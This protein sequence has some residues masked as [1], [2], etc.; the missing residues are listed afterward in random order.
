MH[1]SHD[2]G[3]HSKS[4]RS[5]GTKPLNRQVFS[6]SSAEGDLFDDSSHGSVVGE[7]ANDSKDWIRQH[8]DFT[9]AVVS[10]EM[11]LHEF[12][13]NVSEAE[14]VHEAVE[15]GW[16][17][18][19]GTSPDDMGRL[20]SLHDVPYHVNMHGSVE[21]ITN[22]LA[23]GH[24]VIVGVYADELWQ[25]NPLETGLRELLGLDGADHAIVLT[26]LDMSDPANPKVYVND[27]GD[28]HGEGQSVSFGS[29]FGSL[30]RFG[31]H[32]RGDGFGSVQ[33]MRTRTLRCELP[34]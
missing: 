21:D 27:P 2:D 33:F 30:A 28:P 31:Q 32:V 10:Q 5:T 20:L 17:S 12:G 34:S 3:Y 7:P 1:S 14:L 22:E 29:V 4:S 6:R 18:D 16:L 19:H 13:V 23:H 15:H 24:K 25:Q 11:I 8:T 26:G 9:C